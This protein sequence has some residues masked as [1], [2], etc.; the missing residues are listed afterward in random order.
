[1]RKLFGFFLL[2]ILFIGCNDGDVIVTTFNFDNTD[3]Q[4]CTGSGTYLFFKLNDGET[5]SLSLLFQGDSDIFITSDTTNIVLDGASNYVT[6]R[7][8]SSEVA[9]SYFCNEVPPTSPQVTSEY[10]GNSGT[11]ELITI[12]SYDDLDG[13]DAEDE[14]LLDSDEDGILNYFDFD[15]DGDNVPTLLELDT[16]NADGDNNPLTNPKD[17]DGDSIPDY[18]DD[19]D[20]GDGVLTRYEDADMNLDPSDDIDDVTVGPNFLNPNISNSFVIDAY[21]EH[22]FD[23]STN[24]L[25]K[26]NNLVLT[27]GSE[28]IIYE[29][30][31][32]GSIIGIQSGTLLTTPSF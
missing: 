13:I 22:F 30:L 8:F 5:E 19:D 24:V 4:F 18:L 7:I 31:D 2:S 6:Y 1:M 14:G 27:N 17:T 29:T 10:L 3:L 21:R 9:S 12:A 15:D 16:E 20:D 11:G 26:I 28:Q 25:L 32:F 23:F